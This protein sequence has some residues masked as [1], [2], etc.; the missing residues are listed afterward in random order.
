MDKNNSKRFPI[1]SKFIIDQSKLIALQYLP[2][3]LQWQ[4]LLLNKYNRLID[5]D[6]ARKLSI[7]EII[8]Q[9]ANTKLWFTIFHGFQ[10]CWNLAWSYVQRYGCLQIPSIYKNL[11]MN[12]D[13]KLVFTLPREKDE[14]LCILA[15]T[16]Y[17][18]QLHNEFIE[19]VYEIYL[20]RKQNK[21]QNQAIGFIIIMKYQ[22]MK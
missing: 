7:K 12:L 6:K 2:D 11:T 13:S 19:Y 15:L 22:L 4:Y 21:Q 9:Q 17:L 20:L 14:G 3:L 16:Q 1:L 5:I 18:S 8:L 10:T